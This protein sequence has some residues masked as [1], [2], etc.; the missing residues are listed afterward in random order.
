MQRPA[1]RAF[2]PLFLF[3]S[4]CGIL[5]ASAQPAAPA[6]ALNPK[7]LSGMQLFDQHCRVC[8][9]KPLLTSTQYGP[10]LSKNSLGGDAQALHDFIANGAPRM[11]GFKYSFTGEQI[12]AIVAYLKTVPTPDAAPAPGGG[13]KQ[14]NSQAD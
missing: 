2:L 8:H 3:A 6:S 13:N 9:T 12:D 14:D 4:I 1:Y 7:E 5:S 11:P 10:V